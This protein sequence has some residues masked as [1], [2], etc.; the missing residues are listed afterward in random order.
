MSAS[1]RPCREEEFAHLFCSSDCSRQSGAD[2]AEDQ[3][4][5]YTREQVISNEGS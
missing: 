3:S 2:R 4:V 1:C 5:Q